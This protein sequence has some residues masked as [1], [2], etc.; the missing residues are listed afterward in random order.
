MLQCLQTPQLAPLKLHLNHQTLTARG[1]RAAGAGRCDARHQPYGPLA[2]LSSTL[3]RLPSICM[4]F[5]A[6]MAL[7]ADTALSYDTNPKPLDCAVALSL[8]TVA[9]NI[10]PKGAKH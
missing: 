9:D 4:P 8:N 6:E 7:W 1:A 3:R 10:V 2:F 5:M